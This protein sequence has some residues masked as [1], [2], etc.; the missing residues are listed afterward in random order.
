MNTLDDITQN[1]KLQGI[2]P[3]TLVKWQRLTEYLSGLGSAVVAYSGGVDSTFLAYVAHLVLG[4]KSCAVFVQTEAE[5]GTQ[6]HL[7]ERW[8]RQGQ[9]SLIRLTHSSLSDPQFV[10]NPVNRC[11][12]C[13]MAILGIIRRYA[14]ENGFAALLEGQN[15][16]DQTDYRPGRQAVKETGA[17]SPLAKVGLTKAEIRVLAR[18]LG[19]PVWNQPSSPCLASRFPYGNSITRAGLQQVEQGEAY[20]HKLGFDDVRV[21]IHQD[22]ARIEVTP[23]QIQKL[24]SQG[25]DVVSYFKTLGFLYVTVDLQGYRRG[26]LNE[27]L[28]R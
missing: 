12:F 26:S 18:A 14:E 13:K 17:L 9:F 20:L 2:A 6:N 4:E 1:L 5:T 24:I 8:A 25:S 3:E 27:G 19:L 11:Y 16:D 7:A 22:L 21:R 28:N 10:A 23:D 15:Q